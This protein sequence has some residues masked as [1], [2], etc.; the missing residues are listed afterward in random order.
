M[1]SC[2]GVA[3]WRG[4]VVV[5]VSVVVCGEVVVLWYCVVGGVVV[6]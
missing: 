3:V 2:G 4:S 1:V 6:R 5:V